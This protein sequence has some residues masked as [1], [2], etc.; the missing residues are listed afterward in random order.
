MKVV[1]L[2]VSLAILP[3]AEASAAP[4]NYR[5]SGSFV[6]ASQ[7]EPSGAYTT[8]YVATNR[9]NAPPSQ[10]TTYLEVA[11][12]TCDQFACDEIVVFGNI[13]NEDFTYAP[14]HAELATT[15]APSADL[16]VRATRVEIGTGIVTALPPPTGP[17]TASFHKSRIFSQSQ[18]GTISRTSGGVTVKETGSSTRT[19]ATLTG[20]FL[21]TPLPSKGE[22]GSAQG[23][24]HTLDHDGGTP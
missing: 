18:R 16:E 15:I 11:T 2:L 4:D 22:I 19:A 6:D 14:S 20:S 7:A 17:L 3:A 23:M 8:I 13:P 21:G 10:R 5:F 24:T 9:E 12:R 1:P